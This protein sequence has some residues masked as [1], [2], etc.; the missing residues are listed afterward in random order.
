MELTKQVCLLADKLPPSER[1]N[2]KNQICRAAK[3]ALKAQ[4]RRAAI[5]VISN[6]TEGSS[7]KSVADRKR[8]Y[9]IARSSAIEIDAQ[10]EAA[11]ALQYVQSEITVSAKSVLTEVFKSLSKLSS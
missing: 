1:F 11:I 6:I 9:E 4:I 10:I 8:F 3:Y 7:R 2:L 5:S